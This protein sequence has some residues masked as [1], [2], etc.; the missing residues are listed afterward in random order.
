M[1]DFLNSRRSIRKYT[2]ERINEDDMQKI[3]QTAMLSPTSKNQQ[4]WHFII[5]KDQAIKEQ[6]I[7]FQPNMTFGRFA[8]AIIVVCVDTNITPAPTCFVD[9]AASTMNILYAAH[10]LGY[11]ACWCAVYPYEERLAEFSKILYLPANVV[12][13]AA[14]TIGRPA[15]ENPPVPER[16]NEEKI[17]YEKW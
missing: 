17:H 5:V 15:K 6:M 10:A 13:F 8:P 9:A 2:D 11:G 16:F 4:P 7:E 14:V 12:A 3:M 1:L